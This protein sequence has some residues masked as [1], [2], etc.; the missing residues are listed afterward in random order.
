MELGLT[1]FNVGDILEI[2]DFATSEIRD[3]YKDNY[4]IGVG[5]IFTVEVNDG[6]KVIRKQHNMLLAGGVYFIVHLPPL[7][8]DESEEG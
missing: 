4:G 7:E 1:S 8:I 6:M 2:V 3:S 5:D